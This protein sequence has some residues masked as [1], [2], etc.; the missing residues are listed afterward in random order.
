MKITY[1]INSNFFIFP[2]IF[3]NIPLFLIIF[4]RHICIF[5]IFI[6]IGQMDCLG[7]P[8]F[9]S[10]ICQ[11]WKFVRW[12]YAQFVT[13][14]PQVDLDYFIH[15]VVSL[16][17]IKSKISHCERVT[18]DRGTLA[19]RC[20]SGNIDVRFY[21]LAYDRDSRISASRTSRRDR[22]LVNQFVEARSV[23]G[24]SELNCTMIDI[25]VHTERSLLIN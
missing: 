11:K 18:S 10:A 4:H 19:W 23:T 6:S 22:K 5:Q 2:R 3:S 7:K 25:K 12:W 24:S 14:I 15:S 20:M 13:I 1:K 17:M 16:Y 9:F 21:C 8:H